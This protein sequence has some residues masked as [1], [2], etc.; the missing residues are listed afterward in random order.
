M[1]APEYFVIDGNGHVSFDVIQQVPDAYAKLADAQ[2]RAHDLAK[3]EPGHTVV[4]TQAIAYVTCPEPKVQERRLK[5]R[6]KPNAR[7][8]SRSNVA[9]KAGATKADHAS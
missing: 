6:R 7:T 1:S 5:K 2:K 9:A 8:A 4:I 3:S